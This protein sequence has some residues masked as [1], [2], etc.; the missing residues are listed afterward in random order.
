MKKKITIFII[1]GYVVNIG[2]YAQFVS[3]E[4]AQFVATNFFSI[5]YPTSKVMS[6]HV[7]PL[8]KQE[9]P[10]MYAIS[11]NNNWVIIAADKRV[12]PILAY[13]CEDEEVG[14]FDNSSNSLIWGLLDWYNE[15]IE[16]IRCSNKFRAFDSRWESYIQPDYNEI[17]NMN[18]IIVYPL[19][20]RDGA[21]IKWKQRGNSTSPQSSIN[22]YNQF[23]PPATSG[24][25]TNDYTVVG[26]VPLTF[27]MIMWYWHW[28][29]V[30]RMP[31]TNNYRAYKWTIMPYIL[32]DTTP[33]E[34]ANEV[35]TILHNI[36]VAVHTNYGCIASHTTPD[37]IVTNIQNEFHYSTSNMLTRNNYTNS[38]WINMIKTDLDNHRPVFYAGYTSSN[39]N[40][41]EVNS[42]GHAFIIDG[43]DSD[44][45]FHMYYGSGENNLSFYASLDEI[46]YS[47]NQKMIKNIQPIDISCSPIVIPSSDV[48]D[49][50]FMIQ[51]RGG[52]SVGN[53]T[54]TYG[55]NGAIASG[56]YVRLTS[57]FKVNAGARVFITCDEIECEN[58]DEEQSSEIL[59]HTHFAPRKQN[60][61][62]AIKLL[63]DD[64]VII[65]RGDKTYTV[66]GQEVR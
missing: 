4:I 53:R 42:G 30:Q 31:Q 11:S 58:R 63:R 48:W 3:A 36:G 34:Q 64:Q 7:Y 14:I 43:Y 20:Q 10:S 32:Q 24:Q 39:S 37:S 59:L 5:K 51:H 40:K 33:T 23:C 66:T 52:L 16:D 61:S 65:L 47:N 46:T 44:N 17:R 55:M 18:S 19:I 25:C 62:H 49:T 50:N 60:I 15:Q 28:P 6:L 41:N 54:L 9:S 57:G 1:L 27:G 35:A 13:S 2:C 12:Q 56:N 26:C 38:T 8:G 29:L 22:C 21:R 45:K